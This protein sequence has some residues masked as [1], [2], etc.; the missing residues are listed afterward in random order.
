[1]SELLNTWGAQRAS[2]WTASDQPRYIQDAP[3]L[4]MPSPNMVPFARYSSQIRPHPSVDERQLQQYQSAKHLS[5]S[6]NVTQTSIP[7][8]EETK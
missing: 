4:S 5:W 3:R 1:M 2:I 7:E 6:P 8:E